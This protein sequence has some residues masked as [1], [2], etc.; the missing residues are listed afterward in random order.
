MNLVKEI[1]VNK[2]QFNE[3]KMNEADATLYDSK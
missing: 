2:L 3:R 1:Y